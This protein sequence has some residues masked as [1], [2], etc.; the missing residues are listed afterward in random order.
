MI[1]LDTNVISE[2]LRATPNPA[3]IAWLDAQ[4]PETLFLST[5]TLAELHYGIAAW[6]S[7]YWQPGP[8]GL[9]SCN[10]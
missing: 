1:L 6:C 5:V 4:A 8:P 7:V 10:S 3:V 2:P 9:K